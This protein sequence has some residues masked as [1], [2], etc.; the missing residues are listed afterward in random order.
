MKDKSKAILFVMSRLPCPASS[1]RK[2]CLYHYCRILSE[3]LDCRLVVA[4]FLETGDDPNNKADFI[5][6][7]IIL[8]K[9]SAKT[10]L[11]GY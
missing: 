8:P 5:D 7:L 6:K 1:G 10:C 9:A 2:I 11:S 4:S 3:D